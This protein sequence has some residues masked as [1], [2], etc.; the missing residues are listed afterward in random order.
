M[1]IT[2]KI[3]S[4]PLSRSFSS[5]LSIEILSFSLRILKH[6]FFQGLVQSQLSNLFIT[7]ILYK[8]CSTRLLSYKIGLFCIT[9]GA[10]NRKRK[11]KETKSAILGYIRGHKGT[12]E[13]S[14]TVE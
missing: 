10:Q 9:F 12:L 13:T 5:S 2:L 7:C 4:L 11:D 8:Y 1:E 3:Y 14:E 6:F